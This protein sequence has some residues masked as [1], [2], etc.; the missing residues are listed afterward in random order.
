M[1]TYT[2]PEAVTTDRTHTK[3]QWMVREYGYPA[4]RATKIAEFVYMARNLGL[5][6]F[7][8]ENRSEAS[9]MQDPP[10]NADR[11]GFNDIVVQDMQRRYGVNI[12][13]DPRFDV[14]S[15]KFN[16]L[17]PMVENWHRLRG[18]YFTQFLQ[19]LRTALNGVDPKIQ[20][21]VSVAGERIGPP[22]GNWFT[23]WRTWVDQGLI[24]AIITPCDFDAWPTSADILKTYITCVKQGRGIVP[25]A[26]FRNYIKSSKH[27]DIRLISGGG[28]YFF[29]N[30]PANGDSWRTTDWYDS[31]QMAWFQRWNQLMKDLHEFGYIKF[32]DQSFDGFPANSSYYSGGYG[33]KGYVPALRLALVCGIAWE[34]AA[35]PSH[36]CRVRFDMD[37]RVTPSN[38]PA[39]PPNPLN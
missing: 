28:S 38:L 19:E 35:I 22:M 12:L 14:D 27:P 13:T 11:F 30:P 23:D 9:Q 32:F 24:D 8:V 16:A 1:Y 17:D 31:Y 37:C 15:P 25:L 26:V 5:K 29:Q 39:I 20:I 33:N 34:T 6:H 36:A 21:C 7:V 18:E 4:A 10:D 2:H 3:K